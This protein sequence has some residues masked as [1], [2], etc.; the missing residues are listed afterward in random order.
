[1][2]GGVGFNISKLRPKGAPIS[3]GGESSGPMS[4]L[5]VFDTSAKAIH[6]GGGRRGAHIVIMNCDHPDIEEFVTYKQGER[7]NRLTQFNISVGVTDKFMRAVERDAG[8]DLVFEGKKYKT[9]RARDLYNLIMENMFQHNEPGI[10]F[11]DEVQRNNSASSLY[12]IDAVNPCFTGDTIVAVADGRNGVPIKDLVG[13]ESFEVYSAERIKSWQPQIKKARAFVTGEREV[14]EVHLS[15]GSSFK[16][17]PDHQLALTDGTYVEAKDSKG[18]QLEQFYSFSNKNSRKSYR[19]ISSYS[20][21]YRRQYRMMWEFHNGKYSSNLNIDHIDGDSTNDSLDNL[22]LL[23]KELHQ[24]LSNEAKK[25]KNNP[26]FKMDQE[27]FKLLQRHKNVLANAKRYKW[28]EERTKKELD[29]LP[30]IPEKVNHN[31]YLKNDLFVVNLIFTGKTETVYDLTVEDNHN[32]YIL[33]KTDDEKYLN[34]SGILVHNCGEQPLPDY[35][36]CCLGALNLTEFIKDPFTDSAS[37]DVEEYQKTI[38]IAVRFLD[39]VLSASEYPLEKIKEHVLNERRIGL[40]YTGLGSA[41]AMLKVPYGSEKSKELSE[42]IGINLRNYSYLASTELAKE[43][44]VFPL[45]HPE[46]LNDGFYKTLPASIK[47]EMEEHGMRNIALNTVAPTGT[48]SMTVGKNCSSGIEPIFSLEYNRTI[49]QDDDSEVTERVYDYAWLKYKDFLGHE[50]EEVPEFFSTTFDV[51]PYDALEIQGIFQKYI[52]ASISKTVN[53]PENYTFDEFKD[54]FMFAW[55]NKLKGFTSFNPNGT[56]KGILSNDEPKEVETESSCYTHAPKRP[57]ELPCDMYEMM[58]NKKRVV[59][60]VGLY[61]DRP[62]EVFLTDDPDQMISL[63]G[64]KQGVIERVKKNTYQL[65]IYGKRSKYSLVITSELF[66]PEWL[67]LG[68]MVSMALRHN[69]SLQFIVKQLNKTVQFGTFSKGMARVLKKYFT[70]TETGEFCP[71]C[72]GELKYHDGCKV[73]PN[74]GWSG[75]S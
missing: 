73:C 23:D 1:M 55:K 5:E 15:D 9:L 30:P 17:T 24:E 25:G 27:R 8:W 57:R 6:T 52:D 4:F 56:M 2:G 39:N 21:G 69:I 31:V 38:K 68:R 75:C 61:E 74:C 58:V 20:N 72:G 44:G 63:R 29:K 10:F 46:M 51:S 22:R 18:K 42:L 45:Y 49:R 7:N 26:V 16:C 70:E 33:T 37:F 53:L 67:A 11:L 32:F 59:A 35:G 54:L 66:D 71:E 48:S 19:H 62:Y 34:S 50:P 13:E 14:I 60:L 43:K 65:N 3:K 12:D 47:R 28:S 40:G 64:A 36:C 41:F